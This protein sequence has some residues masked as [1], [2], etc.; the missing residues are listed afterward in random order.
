MKHYLPH[1]LMK[2]TSLLLSLSLCIL[3]AAGCQT[4]G[5]QTADA[6]F[7]S[8]T[9]RCFK[10][11]AGRDSIRLHALLA[12]PSRRGLSDPHCFQEISLSA[13]KEECRLSASLLKDLQKIDPADLSV[14]NRLTR[15]LLE[16]KLMESVESEDYLLYE[17]LLG[18]SGL[19]SRIL[20]SLSG[21][22]FRN[23]KDVENYLLLLEKL[24][25][26]FAQLVPEEE[27]RNQ[28]GYYTPAFS[29]RSTIDQIDSFLDEKSPGRLLTD[30]F[31]DRLDSLP[32]L[33]QAQREAFI[34]R[35]QALLTE[36]VIPACRSLR[37]ELA[38]LKEAP[39][40]KER[41]C[42]YKEGKD[43]YQWLI[44]HNIGTERSPEDCIL[45]LEGKLTD[46]L[47]E[48][49][50]LHEAHPDMYTDYLASLPLAEEPDAVLTRLREDISKDFPSAGETDCAVKEAP[51]SL[52]GHGRAAY[53]QIP[54]MDEADQQI[55][56]IYK[57][58]LSAKDLVPTLAHEGYPGH[59]YQNSY[60]MAGHPDP[61]RALVRTQGYDEG[62]GT[63]AELYSYSY[64]DFTDTDQKTGRML[65]TLYRDNNLLS[66]ILLSLSDLYVNYRDYD[67]KA[68]SDYL[69]AY[70]I[71]GD[72]ASSIYEYVIENPTNYL[73]Y[74][75][76]YYEFQELL[77]MIRDRQGD[78]FDI[79]AFHKAVLDCGSCPFDLVKKRLLLVFD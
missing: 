15:D 69:S 75:I 59:L 24:P 64:M 21:Y 46:L 58:Q 65:R 12:S 63:Y 7:R 9:D 25:D 79:E 30:T 55:I 13:R 34:D 8:F 44:R 32:G 20:T 40:G 28:E 33:S 5:M 70:G 6:R 68:L 71:D 41:L 37:K 1:T 61:V 45:L 17:S 23:E 52:S 67:R 77:T 42:Q 19:P 43:Y 3:M 73:A 49:T 4:P 35:N 22:Y 10:E 76:G 31:E 2:F 27:R 29:I 47:S 48:M 26:L 53:Y 50:S 11:M 74:S 78:D 54:P 36:E 16:R 72:N 60:V 39:Q 51:A 38:S 56:Y 62:W 66:L 57:D 14:E 18:S